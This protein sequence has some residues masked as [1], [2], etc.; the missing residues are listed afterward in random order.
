[1][2]TEKKTS[3]CKSTGYKVETKNKL[4]QK[5]NMFWLRKIK[6]LQKLQ[7]MY[8]NV[9]NQLKYYLNI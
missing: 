6:K 1:M 7:L 3:F 8:L 9:E 5:Q 2:I 4:N